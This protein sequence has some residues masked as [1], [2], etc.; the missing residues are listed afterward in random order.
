MT[1][2]ERLWAKRHITRKKCAI[3]KGIWLTPLKYAKKV[4]GSWVKEEELE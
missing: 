3:H 2:N 4:Y 1:R